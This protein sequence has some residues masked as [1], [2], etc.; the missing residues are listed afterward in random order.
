MFGDTRFE[1]DVYDAPCWSDADN[2]LCFIADEDGSLLASAPT[3]ELALTLL[4]SQDES[5]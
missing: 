3:R 2:A 5:T 1:N 4:E